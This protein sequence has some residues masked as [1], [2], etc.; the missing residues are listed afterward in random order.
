[1]LTLTADY[2]YDNWLSEYPFLVRDFDRIYGGPNNAKKS[3]I[4]GR[5]IFLEIM[6]YLSAHK[7]SSCE[8]IAKDE[9]DKKP[10]GKRKVKSITDDVRKF[11]KDNL[12][13]AIIVKED[14][15]KKIYNKMVRTYSLTSFGILYAIHLDEK[16]MNNIAKEYKENIPKVFGN[17]E[18]FKKKFGEKFIDI[19][20]IKELAD[21]G[22]SKAFMPTA[23]VLAAFVNDM[24]GAY[25]SDPIFLGGRWTDQISFVVYCNILSH[26]L[27]QSKDQQM[28]TGEKYEIICQRNVN[29]FWNKINRNDPKI[30]RWFHEC[31]KE[32]FFVYSE[33]RKL[34]SNAKKWF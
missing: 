9:Y 15:F 2:K 19:I 21:T 32:A 28:E 13:P 11:I 18:F 33:R 26:I 5:K 16:N 22:K 27:L 14:G 34:L 12:I 25:Y 29:E 7:K 30:K 20:G 31:V 4:R 10:S 8:D 1:M 24:D 6:S 17:F 3:F 23:G